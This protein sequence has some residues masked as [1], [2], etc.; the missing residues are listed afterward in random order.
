MSFSKEAARFVR[1][2]TS[3]KYE[4][5]QVVQNQR[6]EGKVR[7]PVIATLGR[8]DLLEQNGPI[9]GLL[10]S[11]AR[12]ANHSAVLTAAR[13]VETQANAVR[14]GPAL[15]FERLWRDLGFPELLA[16]LLDGRKFGFDVE[17]A[18]FLTVLHR[19]FAPGSDR[20]AERWRPDYVIDGV[21]TLE[22]HH[23]YR[24][25]AW[26]GEP[27]ADD[28]QFA[29]TPFAPRCTKDRIEE[30]L[31]ARHRD[32][33]S[34]LD[35]VFFDTTSIDFE[36]EG[37]ETI[38]QRGF[39]KDP[40][41]DLKP[42]VVGVV[43]DGQGRPIGCELWPG[44]TRDVK[45]MIPSIDRLRER[46]ALRSIC[47]VADRGMISKETI[48]TLQ[49]QNRKIHFLLGARLRS[50]TEI[51]QDVLSRGGRYRQVHGPRQKKKDPSPLKVKEVWIED[52]RYIVG[53]NEEQAT[54]DAHERQAILDSLSDKLKG[55]AVGLVGNQGYRRYLSETASGSLA[56]DKKK[57]AADARYDGKWVLMT[58]TDLTAEECAL[59]YKQLQRVENI[60]RSFKSILETRPIYHQCDE[61]IRGHVFCSFLA[62][63]LLKELFA[64]LESRGWV[65]EWDHLRDD[66]EALQEFTVESQGQRF[67]VRTTTRGEAGKAI[68][69][70]GVRLGSIVQLN[71]PDI[72]APDPLPTPKKN[73]SAKL[74][75][76]THNS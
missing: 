6:E 4:Y 17:R 3:G 19:L 30:R 25:L 35:L 27:L 2:K 64:R 14:I 60:F 20:A 63:V 62:M 1:T 36:G 13:H 8:R 65:G 68:Q 50:V 18:V 71:P 33:F 54:K 38:G 34:E 42:M 37:G 56:L 70:A 29:K 11:L 47:I 72:P 15:V 57:I 41:P 51:K 75:P 67:V 48:A 46:F 5:L 52:R 43:V 32:L 74:N 55:G 21:E 39:S 9:D 24:A 58:D 49:A 69:A 28:P 12:F 59:K 44:N 40:R 26:L 7:Q 10:A 53:L 22:L 31:F 76:R 73:R 61:T 66:L 45:T 16:E 23:R